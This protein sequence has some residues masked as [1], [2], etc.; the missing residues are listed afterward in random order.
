MTMGILLGKVKV[1]GF[2]LFQ[3]MPLV[4]TAGLVNQVI[5]QSVLVCD[6]QAR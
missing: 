3:S 4:I 1:C 2:Q 5:K 6:R